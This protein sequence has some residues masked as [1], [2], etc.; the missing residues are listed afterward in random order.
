MKVKYA[1]QVMSRSVS[2]S[3]KYCR[4]TLNLKEF[5]GSE[6]TEEFLLRINDIFDLLNSRCKYSTSYYPMKNA[7]SLENKDIWLPAFEKA[8]NYLLG[9]KNMK[10]ECLVKY[11]SRKIGFLGIL[12]NI[13]AIKYL[14]AQLVENGSMSYLCTYKLS[15][16]P[17]EHLFWL[18]QNT[19]WCEQQPHA[20]P[21]SKYI[22][23]TSL[24][25]DRLHSGIW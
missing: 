17:L 18:D 3:L 22:Q 9:L 2:L 16:N 14:F 15:Q 20:I 12:C 23:K 25:R 1:A 6:A 13:A 4:E 8:S 24:G 21:I 7:L 19:F 11:D 10:G 5:C